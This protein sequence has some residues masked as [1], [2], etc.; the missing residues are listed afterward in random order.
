MMTKGVNAERGFTLSAWKKG[1][2]RDYMWISELTAIS[3]S[4]TRTSSVAGAFNPCLCKKT[5]VTAIQIQAAAKT[6]GISQSKVKT[7]LHRTRKALRS[8]LEKEGKFLF[9]A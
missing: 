8:Y 3:E 6:M 1:M 4:S 2:S 9:F 5:P 7:E